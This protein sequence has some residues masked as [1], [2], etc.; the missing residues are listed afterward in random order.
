MDL[1]TRQKTRGSVCSILV[2]LKVYHLSHIG[3]RHE[4][5]LRKIDALLEGR[6]EELMSNL[7]STWNGLNP[8]LDKADK[9][10]SFIQIIQKAV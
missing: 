4:E 9:I 6:E 5:A 2:A 8:R 10:N 7:E 1:S 3:V